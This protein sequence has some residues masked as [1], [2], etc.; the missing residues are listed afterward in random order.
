MTDPS[1]VI[2]ANPDLTAAVV[3]ISSFLS[4]LTVSGA[5]AH[6]L[7]YLKTVPIVG[8]IW[9]L[10]DKRGKTVI[11]A[12]VAAI[13]SLGVTATF[14]HDPHAQAGVYA[15]VFTGLTGPS[16]LQHAWSFVQ[17]WLLLQGWYLKYIKPTPVTGVEPKP[18]GVTG[19]GEAA[20]P[21]IVAV[22]RKP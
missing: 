13:G 4:H 9:A 6:V 3:Q 5:S 15:L 21:V 7:E 10:L 1:A 19:S 12:I 20:A 11:G 18:I 22:D 14:Q 16:M 2:V 8:K 17:S